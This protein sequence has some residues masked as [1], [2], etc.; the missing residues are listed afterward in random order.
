M[1][2]ND[3]WF[4]KILPDLN[5][6]YIKCIKLIQ[7]DKT[8]NMDNINEFL[9]IVSRGEVFK[10]ES[11]GWL[12]EFK[13]YICNNVIDLLSNFLTTYNSDIEERVLISITD[14]MLINDP[15]CE[16]AL[17]YKIKNQVKLNNTRL[18]KFTYEQFCSF[19][20]ELYGEEYHISF[21]R[22]LAEQPSLE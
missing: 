3:R 2:K 18:A 11:C 16:I 7:N 13:G 17:Y 19:Y 9:E 6:D 15:I 14:T 4:L 21:E 20:R 8:L 10:Y 1:F 12:D 5:C 22:I